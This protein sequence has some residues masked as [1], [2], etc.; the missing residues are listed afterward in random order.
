[1]ATQQRQNV[2][3]GSERFK[4]SFLKRVNRI[5][6]RRGTLGARPERPLPSTATIP[7]IDIIGLTQTLSPRPSRNGTF[8][9]NPQYVRRAEHDQ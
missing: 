2:Y 9:P 4:R 8:R 5:Q 1:M 7:S 6:D 3:D